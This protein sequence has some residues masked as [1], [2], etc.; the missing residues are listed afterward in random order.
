MG[1]RGRPHE[2][3]A[4]SPLAGRLASAVAETGAMWAASM[5]AMLGMTKRRKA[6]GRRDGMGWD[7]EDG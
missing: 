5:A 3:V 1:L 7:G 4:G 6:V 2:A